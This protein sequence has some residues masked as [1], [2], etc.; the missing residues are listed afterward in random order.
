MHTSPSL[1]LRHALAIMEVRRLRGCQPARETS[2]TSPAWRARLQPA[3]RGRR[4]TLAVVA[5]ARETYDA[6]DEPWRVAL[7]QAWAS[8]VAGS[9][10][11]GAVISDA[12]GRIVAV[13][14]NRIVEERREPGVLASTFLAHAEMNALALL[15]LGS[16][17]GL[18]IST[19]FEPCLMCSSAIL[20]SRIPHIRYAAADPVFD[21]LHDWFSQLPFTS[22]RMPVRAEL[23]GRVGAFAHVL[24][25]SWIAFWTP[26]GPIIDAHRRLRPRHLDVAVELVRTERLTKVARERGDIVDA[27]SALWG[28]LGDLCRDP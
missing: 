9:S 27:L 6:L 7:A 21:G 28:T 5:S 19:T 14:R 13:G 17:D 24:H 18:T 4:F 20:Q 15:R 11:V 12:D 22:D 8:W 25:V 2:R 23:G 1:T 3:G 16:P 26:D 10:G